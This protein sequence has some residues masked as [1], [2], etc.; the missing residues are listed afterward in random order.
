MA[1]GIVLC[2]TACVD[3]RAVLKRLLLYWFWLVA[4]VVMVLCGRGGGL[5]I[6]PCAGGLLVWSGSA[7]FMPGDLRT[8]DYTQIYLYMYVWIERKRAEML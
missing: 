4:C 1:G 3:F 7:S 6:Y 5:M 2:L 8:V